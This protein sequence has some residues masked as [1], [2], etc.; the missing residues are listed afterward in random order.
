MCVCVDVLVFFSSGESHRTPAGKKSNACLTSRGDLYGLSPFSASLSGVHDLY[1]G[2]KGFAPG[3]LDCGG[4]SS[5]LNLVSCLPRE[6]G[7]YY[8]WATDAKAI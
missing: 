5:L 7:E 2:V 1:R 3:A 4:H 8:N 6:H